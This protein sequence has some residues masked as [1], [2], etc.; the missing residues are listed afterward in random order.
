[1]FWKIIGLEAWKILVTSQTSN[2]NSCLEDNMN[3]ERTHSYWSGNPP[4]Y[5]TLDLLQPQQVYTY[6]RI[7]SYRTGNPSSFQSSN[8]NSCLGDSLNLQTIP[9]YI[10]CCLEDSINLN[11]IF[12]FILFIYFMVV[13]SIIIKNKS[14]YFDSN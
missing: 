8:I 12:L 7:P 5:N 6:E 14:K 3:L 1:M 13:Y 10:H 11:Y 4:S 2:I 9:D